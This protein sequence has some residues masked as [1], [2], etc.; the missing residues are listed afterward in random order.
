MALVPFLL[1]DMLDDLRR[2]SS[3]LDQNFG[4]G[5]LN[6][7]LVT[8][9]VASPLQLFYYRP[10]RLQASKESGISNV[11]NDKEKFKV[12]LDVQQFEP[13]EVKVKVVDKYV[14][15]DGKHEERK[16]EHGYISREFHR[17]YLLPDDVNVDALQSTLSSDGVLSIEA[18]K[19]ALPPPE[20]QRDVPITQTN[21]PAV[22]GQEKKE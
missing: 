14:T 18:P 20:N 6:D 8:P 10:W 11:Q 9:R 13:E 21:A 1:S 17:R 2:P 3:L 15:I 12:M 16:D 7:D 5:L 4:L 19:K 22:K